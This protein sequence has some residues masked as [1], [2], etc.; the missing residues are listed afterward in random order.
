MY[1]LEYF[2]KVDWFKIVRRNNSAFFDSFLRYGATQQN[3]KL[4]FDNRLK[5][6]LVLGRDAYASSKEFA[7]LKE[8][9]AVKAMADKNFIFK[10]LNKVDNDCKDYIKFVDILSKNYDKNNLVKSYKKYQVKTLKMISHLWP[11]LGIEDY[12][13]KNIE[14]NLSKYINPKKNFNNFNSVLQSLISSD[15]TTAIQ[16]K[17]KAALSL[18]IE[19]KN[20]KITIQSLKIKNVFK[21]YEYIDDHGINFNGP[22]LQQ[23]KKEISKIT[24]NENP[25]IELHKIVTDLKKIR[26]NRRRIIK[27]YKLDKNIISLCDCAAKLPHTRLIRLE[28]IGQG[29]YKLKDN[30]FFDIAKQLK[31]K[32]ILNL[33]NWEIADI[34]QVGKLTPKIKNRKALHYFAVIGEDTEEFSQI[35][36]KK[37]KLAIEKENKKNIK[38]IKGNTAC[39]GKARGKV[40]IILSAKKFNDFKEGDVL[41]T[42]MTMPDY[43][44]IMKKSSAIITDEGGIS[45]H[46]AIV[47]RELGKPCIIGT[48]IA[49]K[50]LK[51]GDM[52][53]VDANKGI[54]KKI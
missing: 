36:A 21:K 45:C 43:L 2:K 6:H 9:M 17:R 22:T 23:F 3:H 16:N 12:L 34:L 46:A 31:I 32:N 28:T 10:Y 47:S 11:P 39:M 7:K 38:E 15:K 33:Y 24:K 51:N 41:V 26:I 27:Q 13:I 25:K 52:V 48:K 8:T 29:A 5:H 1:N 4:D 54:I 44:P 40:K 42:S 30:L 50:I 14:D 19:L 49:T 35:E 20:R 18:S 53:D 37:I